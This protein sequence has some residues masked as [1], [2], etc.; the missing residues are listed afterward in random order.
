MSQRILGRISDATYRENSGEVLS[1]VFG[2]IP[3]G[4]PERALGSSC[5]GEITGIISGRICSKGIPEAISTLIIK[6]NFRLDHG[7][8]SMEYSLNPRVNVWSRC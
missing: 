7:D 4:I 2:G 8:K 1:G 6:E 3:G 5:F